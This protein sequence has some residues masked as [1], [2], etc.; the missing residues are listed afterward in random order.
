MG[1][2]GT[3]S[4]PSKIQSGLSMET[5][6]AA[7]VLRAA[8]A[9]HAQPPG[10]PAPNAKEVLVTGVVPGNGRDGGHLI[11]RKNDLGGWT[12]TTTGRC[13]FR[14][15]RSADPDSGK[16]GGDRAPN[17]APQRHS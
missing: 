6:I 11:M 1:K 5:T 3:V 10:G 17:G 13:P 14:G 9:A 15:G 16:V 8:F 2:A 7:F 4:S 12:A